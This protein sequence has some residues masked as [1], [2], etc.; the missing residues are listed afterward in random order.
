[1]PSFFVLPLG[2]RTSL[3]VAVGIPILFILTAALVVGGVAIGVMV[4]IRI[5]KQRD[6]QFRRMTF[7][8]MEDDDDEID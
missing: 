6:I 3:G 5:K 4:Y 8:A 2:K 7:S 1:M